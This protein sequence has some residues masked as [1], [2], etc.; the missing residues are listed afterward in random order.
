MMSAHRV[1]TALLLAGGL[2]LASLM[3][4]TLWI[5]TVPNPPYELFRRGT[6]EV[7]VVLPDRDDWL[8]FH[9]GV[10]ICAKRGLLTVLGETQD[11]LLVQSPRRG[12]RVHFR[13]Q[14]ASGGVDTRAMVGRFLHASQPPQV[15]IGSS[16]TALT[17]A[18]AEALRDQDAADPEGPLLLVPWASAGAA[19]ESA[20]PRQTKPLLGIYPGRTF[21]FSPNNPLQADLVVRCVLAQE[22]HPEPGRAI[23]VVDSADPYSEDLAAA[24]EEVI[25]EMAPK[26][27][28]AVLHDVAFSPGLTD[29]PGTAE[30]RTASRLWKFARETPADRSTWVVLPL[31]GGPTRRLLTAL[32][33]QT[34]DEETPPRMDVLCGDGI[35]AETLGGIAGATP[36]SVWSASPDLTA[37]IDRDVAREIQVPAEIVSSL[38]FALDRAEDCVGGLREA[39]ARIDLPATDDAAMGRQIAFDEHGGRRGLDLARVLAVRPERDE[40]LSFV[41]AEG[42]SWAP[43]QIVPPAPIL[44]KP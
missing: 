10:Q 26:V 12:V 22:P 18:L 40:V 8:D 24:F 28:V 11:E 17:V 31:Q 21:R 13:W 2:A 38:I 29:A 27:E 16:N 14:R 44:A 42:N 33:A 3:V 7:A 19:R 4:Y 1:G 23:L 25:H 43:P 37:Q 6:V 5:D 32:K 20:R 36:F 34:P 39:L 15:V 35:G 41:P 30:Y 9:Q